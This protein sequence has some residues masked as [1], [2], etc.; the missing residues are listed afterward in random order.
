MHKE[1][2]GQSQSF[3]LGNKYKKSAPVYEPN[4]YYLYEDKTYCVMPGGH[5]YMMQPLQVP[6]IGY[7]LVES[8]I[9]MQTI[10]ERSVSITEYQA[11]NVM[12]YSHLEDS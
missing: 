2:S 1:Q 8:D 12:F 10:V 5:A 7:R 11:L 4:L 9:A 6:S 3:K